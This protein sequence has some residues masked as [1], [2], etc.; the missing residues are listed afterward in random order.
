MRNKVK[1]YNYDNDLELPISNICKV[2]GVWRGK[3]IKRNFH[4]KYRTESYIKQCLNRASE[5]FRKWDDSFGVMVL[6]GMWRYN[7]KNLQ[8]M[9]TPNKTEYSYDQFMKVLE[10][11]KDIDLVLPLIPSYNVESI[12]QVR[13]NRDSFPG[14]NTGLL[15]G[16]KRKITT[17]FTKPIAMQYARDIIMVPRDRYVVDTSLYHVGGREKR[18]NCKYG[19]SKEVKTRITLSPEDVP[20]IIGQSIVVPIIESLQK[21]AAGMNWAGRLNGRGQFKD[22]VNGVSLENK[23]HMTNANT[24][25]SGHDNH[26][27]EKEMVFGMALLRCC[28]PEGDSIDRLFYYIMSS[29]I[30]KRI[31]SPESHIIY[32]IWKGLPSGHTFTS[33]LTT[34]TAY[35]KIG[36]AI[37]EVNSYDVSRIKETYL[38]G[39]GDDWVG[40]FHKDNIS[41]ISKHINEYSGASCDDFALDSG[42][43]TID[44]ESGRPTF[45]KKAYKHGLIAWNRFELFINY[46]YPTSTMFKMKNYIADTMIHCV[47]GPFD[48]TLNTISMNLMIVKLMENHLSSRTLRHF[49]NGR[50]MSLDKD[51]IMNQVIGLAGYNFTTPIDLTHEVFGTFRSLA[52]NNVIMYEGDMRSNIMRIAQDFNGRILKS[53][54]W[55]LSNKKYMAFESVVRLKIFDTKKQYYDNHNMDFKNFALHKVYLSYNRIKE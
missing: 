39:A 9:A 37:N 12:N 6:P 2:V 13:V 33:I 43:I 47:S 24:D 17:P 25:F 46:A 30:C 32:E 11:R 49:M 10:L 31:V 41:E 48:I 29:L 27:N 42:D 18:V 21:L 53:M 45:L 3:Y 35:L 4:P 26:V 1:P 50:D 44:A 34:I 55:M 14:L 23:K 15:L 19:E 36:V 40:R 52:Y 54:V 20:T 16:K 22:L 8:E 38:Q 28:F 5:V 7:C 51:K